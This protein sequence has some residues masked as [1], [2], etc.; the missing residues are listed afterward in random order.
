MI[1]I[2]AH[3]GVS[4][5]YPENTVAAF[6]AA[7]R[8]GYDIIEC[9]LKY[10]LDGELVVL[11]DKTL[12]RTARTAEGTALGSPVKI[13]EI[14]LAVA[15]ALDY[16]SWF[17]PDFAGEP[18]PTL[19]ELLDFAERTQI[20]LK[21]DNCWEKFPDEMKEK[22]LSE[23]AVRGNRVK[24]DM[25]CTTL[26][27]IEA[28]MKKLPFS[29]IHYDGI[30]LSEEKLKQ[31]AAL[32]A[33]RQLTVWVCYDNQLTHWFKGERVSTELC[34]RVRRYGRL[35]L[36]ILSKQSEYEEAVRYGVDVVET[37]GHVKPQ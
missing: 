25:T 29:D 16:G 1:K 28:V 4:S 35:G 24:A 19:A 27:S 6:E 34:E 32:T 13:S 14:T 5:E 12:N 11:H 31:V 2:Q 21:I 3:R 20:P 15:R 22:L 18:I 17:S 8:Q 37:T 23:L 10:T 33:G 36:W 30:D 9:D 26:E 7:V